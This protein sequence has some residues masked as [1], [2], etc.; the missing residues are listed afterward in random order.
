MR[1]IA[2]ELK[3]RLLL[4]PQGRLTRPTAERARET[5]FNLL[6]H[7]TFEAP[8]LEKARVLDAFAGAGT[9]GFE[10]LSRGAAF[11]TFMENWRGAAKTIENNASRLGVAEH[12][13]VL[14][15]DATRAPAAAQPVDIA[16]LDPP[17][18]EGLI[19]LALTSLKRQGWLKQDSLVVAEMAIK[20]EFTPPEGF[21][22]R[23]ERT[24]GSAAKFIFLG[25]ARK[26]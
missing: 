20:E 4:A 23:H 16:F 17:Y 19:P 12:V 21:V 6:I 22:I 1:I 14:T 8:A 25:L 15:V 10:A 26:A 2:G 13:R 3:G 7:G 11:I 5:L 18:G 9:L 24:A